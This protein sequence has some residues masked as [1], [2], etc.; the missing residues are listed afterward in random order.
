MRRSVNIPLMERPKG[1]NMRRGFAMRFTILAFAL[2]IG[3]GT[4]T[5]TL[6]PKLLA[7]PE[8]RTV[9]TA[10]TTTINKAAVAPTVGQ[11]GYLGVTLAS[12]QAGR[13]V[14]ADV[15]VDSPAE[16]AGVRSGDVIL[17]FTDA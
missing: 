6:D 16:K 15:A 13:L 2:T 8:F 4:A 5:R 11:A 10:I 14:V 9:E 7:M 12:D 17:D 3:C 1:V